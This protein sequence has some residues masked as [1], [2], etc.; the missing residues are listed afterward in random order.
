[1]KKFSSIASFVEHLAVLQL[2]EKL[3]LQKGL[4]K[5][6]AAIEKSARDELGLYQGHAGDFP[7][8]PALAP[9]TLAAHDRLGSGDAP[10]IG[11]GDLAGSIGHTVQG[12]EA[13]V[14]STSRVMVYQELGT[15]RM[16]PRPVL[17]PAAIRNRALIHDTLRRAAVEGLLH[18]SG[19]KVAGSE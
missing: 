16:P 8:W 1:M 13:K 18:G 12:L 11:A 2:Q 17:G 6:A 15:S 9:A 7:A 3:A 14:G 10:M 19:V 4:E 5:C